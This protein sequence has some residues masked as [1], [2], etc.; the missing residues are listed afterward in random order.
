MESMSR[1]IGLCQ[2][3]VFH[4]RGGNPEKLC[5]LVRK[6]GGQKMKAYPSCVQPLSSVLV[7]VFSVKYEFG[8]GKRGKGVWEVLSSLPGSID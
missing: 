1:E 8:M 4:Q 3:E 6:F 7:S 2:T 5:A